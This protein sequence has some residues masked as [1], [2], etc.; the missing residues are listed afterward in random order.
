[1]QSIALKSFVICHEISCILIQLIKNNSMP[2]VI[3]GQFAHWTKADWTV[4]H[5]T[6]A[7]LSGEQLSYTTKRSANINRQYTFILVKFIICSVI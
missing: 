1:M 3:V 4:A 7:Q 6:V 5:G 2:K